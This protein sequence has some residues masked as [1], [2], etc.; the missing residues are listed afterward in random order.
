MQ[1]NWR[2]P[3]VMELSIFLTTAQWLP[4]TVL[5]SSTIAPR[6]MPEEYER[7]WTGLWR[8]EPKVLMYP[9]H[10]ELEQLSCLFVKSSNGLLKWSKL[11]EHI[12][13]KTALE[14]LKQLGKNTKTEYVSPRAEICHA[15]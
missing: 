2:I 13:F 6:K 14:T 12:T 5:W 11:Y 4:N 8:H 15:K 10:I 9:T 3:T 7:Y 1:Y